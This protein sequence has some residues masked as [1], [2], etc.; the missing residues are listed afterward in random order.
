MRINIIP[1]LGL[2]TLLSVSCASVEKI[3]RHDLASDYY[4]LKAKGQEPAFIYAKV[5]DDSID[6]YPV[7][8]EGKNKTPDLGSKKSYDI[9]AVKKGDYMYES[10]F[11]HTS[12]DI[13]LSS[14]IFKYR[15]PQEN[16]PGQLNANLNGAVYLGF[17]KDYFK[18]TPS[19][20]PLKE[21]TSFISRIGY[22]F[23]LFAG[24]GIT[25]VNPTVTGNKVDLEYDGIVFQKGIA[26]FITF[27]NFSVGLTCGFDNLLDS[28]KNVWIYNQ[29]P[30]IG[31][32]IGIANF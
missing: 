12:V 24:I 25:P 18:L 16:V 20:S 26:A 11:I 9:S 23:G 30:Y 22:D 28:N 15:P 29:K 7:T 6:I 1:V 2:V 10:C 3:A 21:E 4:K 5:T 27:E 32:A 13:D 14:I 8:K 19:M 17:R 31:L